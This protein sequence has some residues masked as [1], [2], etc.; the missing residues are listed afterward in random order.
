MITIGLL[1]LTVSA[2]F[3]TWAIARQGGM[4]DSISL[5]AYTQDIYAQGGWV[6]GDGEAER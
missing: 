1:L 4:T 5:Y 2:A 3:T 6:P